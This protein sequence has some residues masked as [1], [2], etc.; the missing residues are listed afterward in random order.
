M[1]SKYLF[2]LT[3]LLIFRGSDSEPVGQPHCVA[4]SEINCGASKF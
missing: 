3:S 4:G 1:P 2:I